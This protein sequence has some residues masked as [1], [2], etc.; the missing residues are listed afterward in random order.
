L[1]FPETERIVL[2]LKG[3]NFSAMTLRGGPSILRRLSDRIPDGQRRR[4]P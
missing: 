4:L 3:E 1:V 2:P